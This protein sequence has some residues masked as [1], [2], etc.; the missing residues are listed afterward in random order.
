MFLQ[1]SHYRI[2]WISMGS[3]LFFLRFRYTAAEHLDRSQY[4]CSKCSSSTGATKQMSIK[5]LPNVLC[6]Q[7]KVI[8]LNFS[9]DVTALRWPSSKGGRT[10]SIPDN[11]GHDS[12]YISHPLQQPR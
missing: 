2:V 1:H 6:L 12:L 9:V 3:Y 8:P 4:T 11:I 5:V 10:C 7:L